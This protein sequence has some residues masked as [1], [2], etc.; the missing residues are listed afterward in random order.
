M[1]GLLMEQLH[2]VK[3]L[4]PVANAFAGTV[5]S[6]AVNMANAERT[7]FVIYKGVGTT[8]TATI[9]AEACSTAAGAN[10]TAIPFYYRA[11]TA[12]DTEGTLTK[13]AATGF[14]TTA[15]S[16]QLYA[17]EVRAEDLAALGYNYVRLTSV[18]S[19]AVSVLGGILILQGELR[20]RTAAG[21]TAIV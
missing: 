8:G 15:G 14:V 5:S 6:Q 11:I 3:G 13:V 1:S 19:V 18:E 10:N 21:L 12:G 16:S 17:I 9:T 2:L 7:V 20:F 4:D